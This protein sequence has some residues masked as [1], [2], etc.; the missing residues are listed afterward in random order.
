MKKRALLAGIVVLG[1][2]TIAGIGIWKKN[3]DTKQQSE[4]KA[5][6][7]ASSKDNIE[8]KDK[9]QIVRGYDIIMAYSVTAMESE[10]DLV[11]KCKVSKLQKTV[12]T[13]YFDKDTV[14]RLISEGYGKEAYSEIKSY[15]T[16]EIEEVYKGDTS[17]QTVNY[18][19]IGGNFE[20]FTQ[21]PNVLPTVGDEMVLFL[22]QDKNDKTIYSDTYFRQGRVVL[23]GNTFSLDEKAFKGI[24][25][26]E[27]LKNKIKK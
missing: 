6:V 10:S 14:N 23:K 3:N 8:S 19:C 26:L 15:Y 7:E 5:G 9:T 13:D 12:M 22:I 25:K 18:C 4:P 1:I 16:L 2:V 17:L 21:D 11:V 20:N 27:D 24:D